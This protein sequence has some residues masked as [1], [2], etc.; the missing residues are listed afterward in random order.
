MKEDKSVVASTSEEEIVIV[1]TVEIPDEEKIVHSDEATVSTRFKDIYREFT[2]NQIT[3]FRVNGQLFTF[4]CENGVTLRVE[5]MTDKIIRFRYAHNGRFER[6]FSYAV[7]PKFTAKNVPV[8]LHVTTDFYEIKTAEV[9]CKINKNNLGVQLLDKN[10]AVMLEDAAGF[11]AYWTILEGVSEVKMSKKAQ[12]GEQ[13]FGLG[14]KSCDQNMH[15]KQFE[16]WCT[17]SFAYGKDTDP[18]Y[19]AVP[20]YYGLHDK[21]AYGIFFDNTY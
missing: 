20:F 12:A 9:Q 11:Y 17:D 19:R 10:G 1:P 7:D 21:R 3:D 16:N 18:L 5:V 8:G 14:D 13:F 4:G 6:D 15:G 2:P